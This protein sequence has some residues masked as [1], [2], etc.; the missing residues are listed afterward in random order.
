LRLTISQLLSFGLDQL[1]GNQCDGAD[2]LAIARYSHHPGSSSF[3]LSACLHRRQHIFQYSRHD[4]FRGA[5]KHFIA[6][7]CN[8]A[9]GRLPSRLQH[10]RRSVT[11]PQSGK[12]GKA[13]GR[14]EIAC[15]TGMTRRKM[16][17]YK[18]VRRLTARFIESIV[19]THKAFSDNSLFL[20][21][22]AIFDP[23][24]PSMHLLRILEQARSSLTRAIPMAR[25]S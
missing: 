13:P 6:I 11:F 5:A 3:W 4:R 9:S 17:F 10:P 22:A 15:S 25:G 16:T 19:R 23:S 2:N 1:V 14:G 24:Q 18:R 8:A 7:D 12:W 21:C 20:A